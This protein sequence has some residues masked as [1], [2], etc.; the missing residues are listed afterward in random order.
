MTTAETT[1]EIPYPSNFYS[2]QTP[3]ALDYVAAINGVAPSVSAGAPFTYLDLGCG[4]GFT[5]VLLA[6]AYP[7]CRFIGIDINPEHIAIGTALARAGGL[8]TS[9]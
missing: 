3:A 8:T 9:S 2:Y 5:I 4:D 1:L 6:A 7:A